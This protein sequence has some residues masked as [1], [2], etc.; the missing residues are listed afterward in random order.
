MHEVLRGLVAR[1]GPGVFD[2]PDNFRG[3]LDD[4]LDEGASLGDQNLVVDAV[5]L[6]AYA[7]MITML[8]QGGD[9]ASTIAQAG[10]RLARDRGGDDRI[11]ASWACA[12]LAYA[13]GAIG[14]A[15][16]RNYR[17]VRRAPAVPPTA[18]P[19]TA[20]AV[21]RHEYLLPTRGLQVEPE[22]VRGRWVVPVL[23]VLALVL[24]GVAGVLGASLL[25]DDD[26]E[27]TGTTA[28]DPTTTPAAPTTSPT[29]ERPPTSEPP[30][31]TETPT[32]DPAPI[33]VTVE[34]TCGAS[35]AGDCFLSERVAQRVAAPLIRTHKENATLEVV[36]QVVGQEVSA[37][38][39]GTRSRVWARTDDGGYVAAI[40]LAGID[41]Y[42]VTTPCS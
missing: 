41:K 30:P 1:L 9:P 21:P 3:A 18:V 4:V 26:G 10:A 15:E 22:P 2:D 36:C 20:P 31:T 35:G 17:T 27:P 13:V 42:A 32:D 24:A 33:E 28:S 37:S 11:S 14:E 39:L 6:G 25:Q 8:E 29:T 34:H 5:R 16:V 19:P 7:S 23:L 38:A 40:F 12:C